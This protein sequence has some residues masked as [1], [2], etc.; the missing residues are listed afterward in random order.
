MLSIEEIKK[1]VCT[2]DYLSLARA[3]SLI[4]NQVADGA[5]LLETLQP[6]A[7]PIIGITGPPGAG[8][9][10]LISALMQ[11]WV[12]AG[13]RIAVLS[14]DP[15]SPFHQGAI[16]G[17]RIRMREWYLHPQVFIR[18]LASRGH[19]GG[20][21]ATTIELTTLLQAAGFDR[22]IVETV[23]VG[24]SEVEIAALADTTIVVLVPEAGDEIQMMKSG[25]MEIADI[26][27]VNKSDRPAA[28]TF[29][30][31]LKQMLMGYHRV[32]Q[33]SV[34][35]TIASQKEGITALL[36]AIELHQ[37]NATSNDAKKRL[38]LTKAIQIIAAH[39][40]QSLNRA[41]MELAL[42]NAMQAPHFNIFEF[43]KQ[44]F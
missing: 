6:A 20:L 41:S 39:K 12:L 22:I 44:F 37:K 29:I 10:T 34:V 17:D 2:G 42:S 8:K 24:Q 33:I 30:A 7:V 16:L 25:L 21:N 31:H 18:S 14:I 13:Q 23:G 40:M 27:V 43:A 5:T 19:L 15:S 28:Q 11:D 26:F 35:P 9:S 3:I 1:G 4:E 36:E 38:L 32:D